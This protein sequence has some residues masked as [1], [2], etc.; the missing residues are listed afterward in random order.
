VTDA[1]ARGPAAAPGAAPPEPAPPALRHAAGFFP[2]PGALLAQI[3]PMVRAGLDRGS[4]VALA[5]GPGTVDALADALGGLEAVTLLGHPDDPVGHSGQTMAV[6]RARELHQLAGDGTR[7]TLISEHQSRFDGPDGRFW[8][9]MEAATNLAM[10]G[11]AVELRCFYPELPLHRSVL[12]GALANHPDLLRDGALHPNPR[13][14]SPQEALAEIPV[15]PP[16]LLGPPDLRLDLVATS[17]SDVRARV[18]AGLRAAGYA[19]ARAEDVV[20][21]VNEI[22]TNAVHHGAPPAEL[23]M[24]TVERACV[25]EVHDSGSL[26]D[27][28][29]GVRPPS[30]TQRSGWGVWV[31]RQ[32]CEALHVWRD[33]AG[34]HVRM[35]AAA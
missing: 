19:R 10:A 4:P 18:E 14:R 34:T 31:A 8:P 16:V 29:P 27:P 17:L 21:A 25:V 2:S 9:E 24:W 26:G 3:V 12:D 23:H 5:V 30:S 13:F 15:P 11:A 7:V 32:T 35:H 1:S 28:L 20:F 22:T 6:R 33:G